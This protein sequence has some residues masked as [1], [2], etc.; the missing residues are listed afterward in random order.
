MRTERFVKGLINV[1]NEYGFQ[2]DGE[3]LFKTLIKAWSNRELDSFSTLLEKHKN[4]MNNKLWVEE[5]KT[6]ITAEQCRR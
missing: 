4:L 2:Y 5:I 1:I 3:A 6:I